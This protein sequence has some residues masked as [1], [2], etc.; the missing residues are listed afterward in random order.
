MLKE[1]IILTL[2]FEG[3]LI[4]EQ[5]L[6]S[7]TKE[8][9]S[10][11]KSLKINIHHSYIIVLLMLIYFFYPKTILIIIGSA[12]VFSEILHNFIISPKFIERVEF[13]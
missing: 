7:S 8:R 5:V 4:I 1:I 10:E 6:F 12:L 3:L 9:D 13:P 11:D 2:A